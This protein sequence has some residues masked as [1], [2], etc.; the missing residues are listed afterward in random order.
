[1]VRA[2]NTTARSQKPTSLPSEALHD[3]NQEAWASGDEGDREQA[4]FGNPKSICKAF[5]CSDDVVAIEDFYWLMEG[6]I[7]VFAD[8]L[9]DCLNRPFTITVND[10]ARSICKSLEPHG[11]A[12]S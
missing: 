8:W 9:S 1:M 10:V 5:D 7:R 11:A 6:V 3:L 4:E 2:T 12:Q